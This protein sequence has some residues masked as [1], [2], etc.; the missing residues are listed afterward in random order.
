MRR[1]H[2]TGRVFVKKRIAGLTI[3]QLYKGKCGRSV[4]ADQAGNVHLADRKFARQLLAEDIGRN[5]RE[6]A[7]R[8]AKSPQRNGGVENRPAGKWHEAWSTGL[9][10]RGDHV[11]QGLA[12][13]QDHFGGSF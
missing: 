11:D 1:D 6:H 2:A 10:R 4:A 12:T 8:R 13:A 5:A 3:V 9:G 7:D